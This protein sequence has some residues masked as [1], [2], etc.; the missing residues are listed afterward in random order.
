MDVRAALSLTANLR[1]RVLDMI[2]AGVIHGDG[3][4]IKAM[5]DAA[6]RSLAAGQTY[7]S[8]EWLKELVD[9]TDTTVRAGNLHTERGTELISDAQAIIARLN[10]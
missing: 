5:A 4:T 9:V 7:Q 10:A 6:L 8:V 3:C 2:D 1:R